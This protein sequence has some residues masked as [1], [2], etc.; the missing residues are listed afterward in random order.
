MKIKSVLKA[1]HNLSDTKSQHRLLLACLV[2]F[3]DE[4][5][6]D[7]CR[8]SFSE[9]ARYTRLNKK[10][11]Q[12]AIKELKEMDYIHYGDEKDSEK[13][14]CNVYEI[15]FPKLLSQLPSKRY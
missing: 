11:I 8:L 14:L 12:C 9:L 13:R 3:R 2:A 15:N 1:M 6:D 7:K 5:E 4:N 10:T